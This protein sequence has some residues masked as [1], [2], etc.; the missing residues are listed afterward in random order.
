MNKLTLLASFAAAGMAVSALAQE[1]GYNPYYSSISMEDEDA[2]AYENWIKGKL[3]IGLTVSTFSLTDETRPANRDEDFLGNINELSAEHKTGVA[4]TVSWRVF[5]YL[6]LGV[7]YSKVEARTMNFNNHESDGNAILKGPVFTAEATYPFLEET[8]LPHIG[9]GIAAFSGDFEEDSWWHAGY[10]SPESY[11]KMGRDNTRYRRN[12]YIDVD[13]ESCAFFNI[14]LSVRP[15]QHLLLDVSYRRLDLDPDCSFGY[16]S[17]PNKT[18]ESTGD[19]DMSCNMF[20][21]SAAYVF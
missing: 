10:D 11:E 14:G 15:I 8:I 2:E 16:K 18:V 21:F 13:D 5:D 1:T 12:R 3:S 7:S 19:F 17:G 20:L 9:V 6:L 4:P